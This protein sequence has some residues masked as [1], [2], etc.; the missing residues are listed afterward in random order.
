V[1]NRFKYNPLCV[2]LNEY[3][4]TSME[5]YMHGVKLWIH[6]HTH[7]SFDYNIGDTRVVCNPV[8]YYK[9]NDTWKK[10]LVIEIIK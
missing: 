8:G 6:G 5:A 10:D 1:H 2:T 7:D 4:T 9:E 3:F